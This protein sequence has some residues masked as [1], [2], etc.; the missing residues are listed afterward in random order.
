[1]TAATLDV[2]AL[3]LDAWN[4]NTE[5]HGW[6]I[7]KS[8]RR[9]GPLVYSVLDQL[10]DAGWI[11]GTWETLPPGKRRARRR[12]YRL[13]ATGVEAARHEVTAAAKPR[14]QLRAQPGFGLVARPHPA[15]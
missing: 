2:L 10:E 3:L 12:F 4:E 5:L 11:A 15:A 1:M 8:L 7:M 14:A 6:L 9:S 13:T